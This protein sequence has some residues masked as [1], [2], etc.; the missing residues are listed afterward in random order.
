M[1]QLVIHTTNG[2]FLISKRFEETQMENAKKAADSIYRD[3]ERKMTHASHFI[4][5]GEPLPLH[6][7][8]NHVVAVE[9]RKL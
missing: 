3:I 4:D 5:L 6:I 7:N 2:E 9:V 1:L 8:V